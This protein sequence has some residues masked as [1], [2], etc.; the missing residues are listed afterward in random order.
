M[1]LTVCIR[2]I[3]TSKV[4]IGY[5]RVFASQGGAILQKFCNK[6]RNIIILLQNLLTVVTT[7]V[8][9]ATGSLYSHLK[10]NTTHNL[11]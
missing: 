11:F 3:K 9:K 1:V 7:F 6:T 10:W 2:I 4:H 5:K 8:I